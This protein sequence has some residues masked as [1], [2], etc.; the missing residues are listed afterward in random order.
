VADNA[1]YDV[2]T[3]VS[4][5]SGAMLSTTTTSGTGNY[6][7][8]LQ[9]SNHQ[10]EIQGMVEMKERMKAM[11]EKM[12]RLLSW[13]DSPANPEAPA[14]EQVKLRDALKEEVKRLTGKEPDEEEDKQSPLGRT[15][16]ASGLAQAMGARQWGTL[17]SQSLGQSSLA[18]TASTSSAQ[19][20]GF[21]HSKKQK[22]LIS[23]IFGDK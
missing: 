9:D 4:G 21:T 22:S 6:T 19:L 10:L 12:D 20:G 13:L 16:T 23:K 7:V 15:A 2:N 11:E 3:V 1:G 18:Q 14:E 17:A 8:Q 5:T